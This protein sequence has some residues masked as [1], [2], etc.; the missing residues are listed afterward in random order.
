MK[1]VCYGKFLIKRTKKDKALSKLLE[2]DSDFFEERVIPLV[3]LI[4]K[5]LLDCCLT[6]STVNHGF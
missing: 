6:L 4:Y 5:K 2:V 3:W 1:K